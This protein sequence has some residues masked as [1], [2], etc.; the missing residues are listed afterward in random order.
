MPTSIAETR[1]RQ[2]EATFTK[3]AGTNHDLEL[4]AHFSWYLSV[5]VSGFV[6]QAVSDILARH[7]KAQS[8]PRVGRFVAR[9]VFRQNLNTTTLLQLVEH[10]DAEWKVLLARFVEGERKDALDSVVD[11]R[12]AIAHGRPSTISYHQISEYYRSIKEIIS[13]LDT[14]CA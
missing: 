1:Q 14:L 13:Y 6:E 7:A 2:L 3:V 4:Q 5:L 12:H 8:S 10:F 11:N 9:T